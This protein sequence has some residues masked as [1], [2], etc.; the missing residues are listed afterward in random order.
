MKKITC[1]VAILF[2]IAS[3]IHAKELVDGYI[4]MPNNDTVH[5]KINLSRSVLAS[6][7]FIE[8]SIGNITTYKARNE[9]IK[10]FGYVLEEKPYNYLLKTVDDED[11]FLLKKIWGDKLNL[12]NYYINKGGGNMSIGSNQISMPA[13]QVEVLVIEAPNKKLL[14]IY[15][16]SA[17]E[18]KK[19]KELLADDPALLKLFEE[20]VGD[21][22]DIPNFVIDANGVEQ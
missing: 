7:I 3:N 5:C 16:L 21:I 14:P 22:V 20:R 13:Y 1:L 11:I 12:Y 15:K 6:K 17:R 9:E 2:F 8:D 19:M 18:M 4:I 10:G